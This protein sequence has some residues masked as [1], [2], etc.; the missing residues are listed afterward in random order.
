MTDSRATLAVSCSLHSTKSLLRLLACALI[1][2]AS[3]IAARAE[4]IH[5]PAGGDLQ[6]AL[7]AARP[8]DEV[9]LE[10]GATYVGNFVLP[11]RAGAS[12]Y[13]T[14]R[15][16]RLSELPASRRVSASDAARMARVATPNIGPALVAPPGSSYYRFLGIEFTQGPTVGAYSYSIVELGDGNAPGPQDTPA[17]AP[18]HLD[19]DRC[20]I[21]ARDDRTA[22]H[23]G[24]A[25]N[26]AHTRVT[27]SH[28]SGIKWAGTETQ[29]VAGW[30]GR[31]RS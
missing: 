12:D 15:S 2:I 11:V 16:S 7:N 6:R 8:G 20:L 9:V 19:F 23:R 13:V 29:A 30:N 26:S 18:H 24:I 28:I 3:N 25:L 10:A 21:R 31:G 14:V 27:N 5:V 17:K 22:A 4:T 1:L